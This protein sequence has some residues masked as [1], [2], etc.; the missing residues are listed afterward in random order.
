MA[1][2]IEIPKEDK[3]TRVDEYPYFTMKPSWVSIVHQDDTP[4]RPLII[5]KCGA[6]L[7]IDAHHIH[8]DGTVTASFYH[9]EGSGNMPACGWHVFLKL[10]DWLGY[11]FLPHQSK[12]K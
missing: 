7:G 4:A 12:S 5:C 2:I 6:I 8:K 1:Q 11:E 10:K 3:T 9:K